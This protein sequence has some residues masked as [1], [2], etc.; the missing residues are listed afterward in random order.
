MVHCRAIAWSGVFAL[1]V[2]AGCTDSS[3]PPTAH[4]AGVVTIDGKPI[5]GEAQTLIT[6]RPTL[7]DQANAASAPIVDGRFDVPAAP[8]GAIR[9]NFHI[10]MPIGVK[11]IAPGHAPEMQR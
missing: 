5:P 9:V 4:L 10:Q 1:A 7:A 2:A 3:G 11:S 6:F 8:L